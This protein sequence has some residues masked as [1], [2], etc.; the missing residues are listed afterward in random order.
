MVRPLSLLP[1]LYHH[2]PRQHHH[3]YHQQQ[4]PRRPTARVQEVE[5]VDVQPGAEDYHAQAS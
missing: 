4:L 2:H 5:E 1:P 3:L